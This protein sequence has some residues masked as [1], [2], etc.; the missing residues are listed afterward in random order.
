MSTF[1]ATGE[2]SGQITMHNV[3][4]LDATGVWT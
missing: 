2:K 3:S 4:T 1:S